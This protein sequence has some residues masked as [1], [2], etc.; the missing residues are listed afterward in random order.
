MKALVAI[1][2]LCSIAEADT[3]RGSVVE[4]GSRAP[5]GGAVLTINGEFAASADDGTFEVTLPSRG[6]FTLEVS[7]P[8]LVTKRVR[9]VMPSAELVVEVEPATEMGGET[10][11]VVDIAPG[12]PGETRIDAKLARAVPGGG[13]AAKVVQSM[14]AVA[15]PAAGSAV[16]V[17]W[18]AAPNDTR[19]FVD[20]V[21][22]PALYHVGGY[23]SSVGNDLIGD[24]RLTPAAFGVDRGR[25]IGGVIDIG[26]ADPASVPDWRVQVD[27]LD[28]AA[29]GATALGGGT[30]AGAVR[31]SWLD[32]AIGVIADPATL[33]P[34]APLPTW[35]DA[36]VVYRKQLDDRLTLSAFAI[37]AIDGLERRLRSDD[38]AT[39]TSEDLGRAMV[40]GQVA[41]R[42]ER[43]DGFDS[44]MLWFGRDQLTDVFKF[45]L[46]PAELRSHA[47]VAGARAIQQTRYPGGVTLTLGGDLD[48]ELASYARDGSLSIPAREGD[49]RIFGLPPGDDVSADRW[50]ATTV[51]AAT[52]ATVDLVL[53]RVIATGGARVDGWLLGA[54]RLTPATGIAPSIGTQRIELTADPRGSVQVQLAEGAIARVDAGRYHQARA[55]SDTS[56]QFGTPTLGLEQAWHVTA[57]GQWRRA[58]VAIEAAV[59]RRW[60]DDLVAR[61]LAVTPRYAQSL[62]QD[63]TGSVVGLQVT[64]RAVGWRG[65]SGWL[66]YNLSRSRRRDALIVPGRFFDHDQTHGLIAVGGWERGPW[67]IGGRVRMASGEPR[68]DV[69]GTY[70][71]TRSGRFEPIRGP[72]NGVRLPMYFAA[73]VRGERRFVVG[74]LKAAVYLELQNLTNR[75]NAEEIIYSADFEDRGYLT[76][77]PFLAILGLRLESSK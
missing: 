57:G 66:S 61:D 12:A 13:D 55:G 68:T 10:I 67:S 71:D 5:V 74:A 52:Y 25:A 49:L 20:G 9:V 1:A 40:R 16:V 3:L 17:V 41:L 7:A 23:R 38:P 19:T 26:L 24:I 34:N 47:W 44:A 27:L 22:V 29:S 53:G 18:G 42:R 32:R 39:M 75:S 15:R 43:D 2:A 56:A 8:W 63:G 51:D 30:L 73:D 21:P 33:A 31:W 35:S 11:D 59:Y 14:P 4:R 28:A 37:G 72:H 65:F 60:L 6:T 36:Q 46:V 50:S 77:L 62:T 54:S 69:V 64:A 48:G 45:G 76:G 58:P 70:F